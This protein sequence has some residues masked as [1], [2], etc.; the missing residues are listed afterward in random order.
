MKKYLLIAVLFILS[1]GY[2]GYYL[3]M[4]DK[5]NGVDPNAVVQVSPIS[6]GED[7]NQKFEASVQPDMPDYLTQEFWKDIT[8]EQL[9]EKLKN[10]EDVNKVRPDNG[11]NMLHLLVLYGQYPEMVS[12]LVD[13]GVDYNLKDTWI[14]EGKL[15]SYSATALHY[16]AD[17]KKRS[18]ELVKELLKYNLAIDV[19][20]GLVGA[21]P[22]MWAVHSRADIAVVKLFLEKGANP[23]FQAETS[24]GTPL[25]AASV[26]NKFR[27]IKFIDPK[28][29]QLLLDYKA[30]VTIK[31][32][33]G[34]TA[35]DYMKENT[36]F[37]KTELFKKISSR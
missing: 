35:L 1:A 20:G 25:I 36:E 11:Q 3:Y 37:T 34:K 7:E 10:I 16:A 6:S 21:S 29:I 12:L 19:A 33:E 17:K 24:G 13:A 2:A 22:L 28:T 26:Y 27:D 31:N 30:D 8:P 5:K 23:N 32:K 15:K 14:N 9:K 18:Y 4:Y